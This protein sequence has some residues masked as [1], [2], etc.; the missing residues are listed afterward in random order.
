[1]N[2]VKRYKYPHS[3]ERPDLA[4]KAFPPGLKCF[5]TNTRDFVLASDYEVLEAE[6]ER[7]RA[8]GQPRRGTTV[9][10]QETV[11]LGP[12]W[13]PCVKLPVVVHVRAQRDGEKHISTREGITPVKADDLIMRGVAGEEY[14][15][16]REL[17]ERTYRLGASSVTDKVQAPMV[18]FD[19]SIKT[20]AA[21]TTNHRPSA[22]VTKLSVPD[23][24]RLVP[25]EPTT[26]M[27]DVAVSH[28]LAVSLS[29]DYNWSAYMRDVWL[30]M[31]E[32]AT[33]QK[34]KPTQTEVFQNE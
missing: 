20:Y 17:F 8:G 7:L 33:Q 13:T 5:E 34:Q 14:P 32:E 2:E 9:E 11:D 4:E 1:M 24:W 28:A 12:E 25:V 27:L 3:V 31:V 16:G 10:G 21:N 6:C 30:R 29:R 22:V 23:G 18:G 19:Y 15:I 26:E